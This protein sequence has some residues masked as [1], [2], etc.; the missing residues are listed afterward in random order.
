MSNNVILISGSSSG[1][2]AL[3]ARA[4]AD[5]GE[6]VY[7]GMR[8]TRAA[9]TRP[10]AEAAPTPRASTVELRPSSST[11]SPTGLGRRRGRRGRASRGPASTSSS[12]TRGTW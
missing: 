11:S 6:I 9:A 7:A 10:Q 1:F 8:D 4:L 12:T 2:G 5:Q 3:T